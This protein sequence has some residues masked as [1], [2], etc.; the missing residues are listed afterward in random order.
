MSFEGPKPLEFVVPS[1]SF[2]EVGHLAADKQ[3]VLLQNLRLGQAA[4]L[5]GGGRRQK[6]HRKSLKSQAVKEPIARAKNPN[7]RNRGEQSECRTA[8]GLKRERGE[9]R[10]LQTSE[11]TPLVK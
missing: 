3:V 9:P 10:W 5:G 7:K 4:V 8:L 2:A 11:S 1:Q 6:G